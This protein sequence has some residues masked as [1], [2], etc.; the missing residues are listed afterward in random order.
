M[1][2]F[3]K[4]LLNNID[5]EDNIIIELSTNFTTNWLA[6]MPKQKFKTGLLKHTLDFEF[7]DIKRIL[8]WN[9]YIF[10]TKYLVGHETLYKFM[11]D[12]KFSVHLDHIIPVK[13]YNEIVKCEKDVDNSPVGEMALIE[14]TLNSSK[15]D[16]MS[17]NSISYI[18]SGFY[19]TAFLLKSTKKSLNKETLDLIDFDRY[20]EEE[21][22]NFTVF[23]VDKRTMYLVDTYVDWIYNVSY[24]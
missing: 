1:F 24:K 14:G 10:I 19:L 6:K 21:L 17:K 15:G 22:N 12:K 13:Q 16:D 18:N 20:S 3:S 2:K 11:S 5:N 7:D 9:E 4:L 23:E 8:T